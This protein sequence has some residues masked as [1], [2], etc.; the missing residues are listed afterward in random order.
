MGRGA[1]YLDFDNDGDLDLVITVNGGRPILFRNDGG[2]KN[3][4]LRV[5]LLG[6][7]SNRGGIGALVKVKVGGRLMRSYVKSGSSYLS[8]SELPLTFGI[9]KSKSIDWIEIQ[10]PNGRVERYH[11]VKVDQW[12]LIE[13]GKK[14]IRKIKAGN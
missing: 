2:N 9:G 12:V 3:H 1:A 10:W 13:E 14:D 5:S 4:W 8:Q 6:V 7:E 11:E